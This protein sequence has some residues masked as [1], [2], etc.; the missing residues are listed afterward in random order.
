MGLDL[1]RFMGSPDAISNH[2]FTVYQKGLGRNRG[3]VH[4]LMSQIAVEFAVSF[5]FEGMGDFP[6][7]RLIQTIK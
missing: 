7:E 2:L 5:F 1:Y 4:R 3:Q 6:D